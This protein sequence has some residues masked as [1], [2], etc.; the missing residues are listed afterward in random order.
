MNPNPMRYL[1]MLFRAWRLESRKFDWC[2]GCS[3]L[4][5]YALGMCLCWLLHAWW[6]WIAFGVAGL[7]LMVGVPVWYLIQSAREQRAHK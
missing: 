3:E 5:G 4:L 7:A 2:Y 1:R 6:G